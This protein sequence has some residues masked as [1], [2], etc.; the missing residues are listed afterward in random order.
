MARV[1]KTALSTDP[2]VHKGSRTIRTVMREPSTWAGILSIAAACLTDGVGALT[3][4][5]LLSQIGAGLA[6]VLTK[7]Q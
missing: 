7:E 2:S 1:P 6:L 3:N 5:A 4:P